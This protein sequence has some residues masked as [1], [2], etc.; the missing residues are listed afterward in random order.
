MDP[1]SVRAYDNPGLFYNMTGHAVEARTAFERSVQ[2]NRAQS[3]PSPWPP[4]NLGSLLLRLKKFL[5]AE[6]ALREALRYD[7]RMA[8]AHYHL[9][10][11]LESE[12]KGED[13]VA[14]Y[15][16]AAELDTTLASPLDS[17]GQLYRRLGRTD[18]AERALAEYRKRKAASGDDV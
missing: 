13:A 11:T 2:M 12:G 6:A 18:D 1:S 9:G 10:R 8:I 16:A 3:A 14:E 7:P 15:K 4:A 5:E 17:L